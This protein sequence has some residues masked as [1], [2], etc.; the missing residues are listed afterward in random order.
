MEYFFFVLG[1]GGV[2]KFI[3]LLSQGFQWKDGDQEPLL[4]CFLLTSCTYMAAAHAATDELISRIISVVFSEVR[5]SAFAAP[6]SA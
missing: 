1:F 5:L 4:D 2:L 3:D 6:K